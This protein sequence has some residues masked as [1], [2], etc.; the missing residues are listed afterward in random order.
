MYNEYTHYSETTAGELIGR[1][2]TFGMRAETINGQ[3]VRLVNETAE[4]L[5]ERARQG[6]GPAFLVCDTY[7][8]YGHHVGDI[9]RAYYR[10]VAEEEE[11]KAERDPLKILS[12]WLTSE[13]GVDAA[14]LEKIESE[15]DEEI[16][17]AVAFAVDAPYP[18][19]S[20]V[21]THVYA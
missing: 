11:W 20:E 14:D 18:P 19:E 16:E 3:D 7:R 5:V 17:A 15:V 1:A 2:Q 21:D 12:D 6:G 4:R 9:D 10:P 13:Q 8:Y